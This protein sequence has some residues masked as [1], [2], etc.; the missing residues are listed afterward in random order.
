MDFQKDKLRPVLIGMSIVVLVLG[1][2][3]MIGWF[4]DIEILKS[5]SPTWV[6][7]KFSTA[8]SFALSGIML[9]MIFTFLKSQKEFQ[10]SIIVIPAIAIIFFMSLGIVS[11]LLDFDSPVSELFA[12]EDTG[13]HSLKKGLPSLGTM[14]NFLLIGVC[15]LFFNLGTQKINRITKTIGSF[16]LIIGLVGCTGYLI[17]EPAFYYQI[18]NISGAMAFH[19]AILFSILGFVLTFINWRNSIYIKFHTLKRNEFLWLI[20]ITIGAGCFTW[21]TRVLAGYSSL[22]SINGHF[23]ILMGY[24]GTTLV[25]ISAVLILQR[26]IH[27]HDEME[28][29]IRDRTTAL[30]A[31]NQKLEEYVKQ[32]QKKDSMKEEFSAMISHELKTPI[33]PI[34]MWTDTLMEEDILGKLNDGQKDA[35]EKIRLS[36]WDLKNLVNDVFDSYKMDLGKMKF[37]CK[38]I[39]VDDIMNEVRVN[40]SKRVE[41]KTIQLT[42]STEK[43]FTF[44]S[45]KTRLAQV[46]NNLVNNAIDFVPKENGKIEINASEKNGNAHFYVKDNGIGIHP[47]LHKDLFKKFYQVDTTYTRKHGGTGLG[48]TICK[49]IVDGLGGKIWLDSDVGKG[50]TFHFTLPKNGKLV[51]KDTKIENLTTQFARKRI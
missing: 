3:V 21:M 51:P 33:T 24:L 42:N 12:K 31:S 20:S 23:W 14:I 13:A 15:G 47:D 26:L 38:N 10:R 30:E 29:T 19:T 17:N 28:D 36:A 45:D 44:S 46:L 6:T 40:A 4:L 50:T 35:V 22:D 25:I 5:L 8:L 18:E 9:L 41:G 2:I 34:M 16:I 48:L 39:L 1:L 32:L 49:G 11:N 27:T 43:S 37:N 7:M